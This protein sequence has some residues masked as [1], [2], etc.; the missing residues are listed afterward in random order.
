MQPIGL[1]FKKQR[2]NR[3]SNQTNG[4]L[5]IVHLCLSCGKI[6]T[7]RIAGD[8]NTYAILTVFNDSLSLDESI[9]IKALSQSISL[10]TLEDKESMLTSL[11]GKNYSEFIE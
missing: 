6:S 10:L 9:K 2:P 4:E 1:T 8:D 11:F 5:M 3:Y 7:N